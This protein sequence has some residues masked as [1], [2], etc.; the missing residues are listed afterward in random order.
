[1]TNCDS[2]MIRLMTR[3]T[4]SRVCYLQAIRYSVHGNVHLNETIYCLKGEHTEQCC[5][6]KQDEIK[7]KKR[8][9]VPPHTNAHPPPPT[10]DALCVGFPTSLA[11]RKSC[12]AKCS[13][14]QS[15]LHSLKRTT[16]MVIVNTPTLNSL[17]QL[18]SPPG[19]PSVPYPPSPRKTLKDHSDNSAL[20]RTISVPAP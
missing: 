16:R 8:Y 3:F 11:S 12:A 10:I 14:K 1:M 15:N 5:G 4:S 13:T 18:L 19:F 7:M 9:L 2:C 20:V 6:M 17:E